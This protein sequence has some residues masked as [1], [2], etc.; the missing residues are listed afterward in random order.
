MKNPEFGLFLP[1]KTKLLIEPPTLN[2]NSDT[3]VVKV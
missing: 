1:E 3:V 2:F